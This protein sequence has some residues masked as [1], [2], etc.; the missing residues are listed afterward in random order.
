L[1]HLI[2][3]DDTQTSTR[4]NTTLTRDS[5]ATA[6]FEPAIPASER[7][8]THALDCAPAGIGVSAICERILCLKRNVFIERKTELKSMAIAMFEV[9]TALMLGIHVL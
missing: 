5:H 6:G 3:L 9:S 7:P 1:L 4:Q 2:T 8:Q